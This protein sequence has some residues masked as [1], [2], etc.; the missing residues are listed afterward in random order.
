MVNPV[1]VQ[2]FLRGVDY[3][4]RKAQLVEAARRE[5]ADENTVVKLNRLPDQDY[6]SPHDVSQAIGDL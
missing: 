5:R 1:Q 6:S 4:A 3:P 2:R